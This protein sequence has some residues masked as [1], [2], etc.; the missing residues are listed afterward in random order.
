MGSL[1]GAASWVVAYAPGQHRRFGWSCRSLSMVRRGRW[2]RAV[3][4]M[5]RWRQIAGV[6]PPKSW[7]TH[8]RLGVVWGAVTSGS[9]LDI[10]MLQLPVTETFRPR[11]TPG[12]GTREWPSWGESARCYRRAGGATSL[13][14]A[15]VPRRRTGRPG[16]RAG[17]VGREN[18]RW[19]LPAGRIG[20][21]GRSGSTSAASLSNSTVWR[22][23]RSTTF[24][25]SAQVF[26]A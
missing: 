21:G 18:S 5:M 20:S 25:S 7:G 24:W 8:G 15:A 4:K 23:G 22:E 12:P 1:N 17:D 3:L 26:T 16:E 13:P 19:R 14:E 11:V 6:G 2:R 9:T 10:S